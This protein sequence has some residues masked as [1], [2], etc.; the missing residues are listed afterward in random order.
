MKKE[1]LEKPKKEKLLLLIPEN[2]GDRK[3][4]VCKTIKY[5]LNAEKKLYGVSSIKYF[6]RINFFNQLSIL[7]TACHEY[8]SFRY[9]HLIII[10]ELFRGRSLLRNSTLMTSHLAA[11]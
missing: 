10:A 2:M 8:I 9:F 3:L 5:Q 4:S 11:L 1:S 6:K 7:H